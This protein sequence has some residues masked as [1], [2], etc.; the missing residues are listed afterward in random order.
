MPIREMHTIPALSLRVYIG[1]LLSLGDVFEVIGSIEITLSSAG[2]EMHIYG[3]VKIG[4]FG[5]I[6]V[7][8]DAG[9][10]IELVGGIP[11]PVVAMKI[12]VL[13]D[14]NIPGVRI[15]GAGL[16]QI[17]TSLTT[18]NTSACRHSVSRSGSREPS[19]LRSS[20]R[21]RPK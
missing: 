7:K 5:K 6:E 17:N 21:L 3:K 10:Y 12:S 1:G 15:Y 2:F 9:L 20:S 16:F 8:G 4:D 19:K 18:P 11:I 14:F 13:I